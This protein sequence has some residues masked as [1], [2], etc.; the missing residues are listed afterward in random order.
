MITS[1]P[2]SKPSTRDQLSYGKT[3]TTLSGSPGW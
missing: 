2:Q 3:F 1:L